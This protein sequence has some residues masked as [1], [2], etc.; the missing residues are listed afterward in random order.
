MLSSHS[1]LISHISSRVPSFLYPNWRG[2]RRTETETSVLTL[3]TMNMARSAL[4]PC[5]PSVLSLTTRVSASWRVL[6]KRIQSIIWLHL[7]AISIDKSPSTW[8]YRVVC[9]VRCERGFL[10]R[11]LHHALSLRSHR[12]HHKRC[13][14]LDDESGRWGKRSTSWHDQSIRSFSS[15]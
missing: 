15:V 3:P 1:S 4:L 11:S 5:V 6:I 7:V 2:R 12:I 10:L 13:L 8:F 9:G 14:M